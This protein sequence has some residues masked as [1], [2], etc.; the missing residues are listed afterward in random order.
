M[1]V[2]YYPLRTLKGELQG[3]YPYGAKVNPIVHHSFRR[4]FQR[5]FFLEA[6]TLAPEICPNVLAHD[7]IG[8]PRIAFEDMPPWRQAEYARN[9]E[10]IAELTDERSAKGLLPECRDVIDRELGRL[11][12][13]QGQLECR[14]RPTDPPIGSPLPTLAA[15]LRSA[16][17]LNAPRERL[18]LLI[19][20]LLQAPIPVDDLHRAHSELDD[21]QYQWPAGAPPSHYAPHGRTYSPAEYARYVIHDGPYAPVFSAAARFCQDQADAIREAAALADML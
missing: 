3:K 11:Q 17:L 19:A 14:T 4:S 21:L 1:C 16:E 6:V 18:H 2:A 7:P 12:F 5:A 15:A 13:R 10:R 20:E 9:L 8:L